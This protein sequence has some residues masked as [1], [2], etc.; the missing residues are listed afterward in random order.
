MRSTTGTALDGGDFHVIAEAMPQLVWTAD[1]SGQ[2]D[3]FNKRWIDYTG[4]GLDQYRERGTEV[5]V[6][7]PDDVKETWDRWNRA[8]ADG[9]PYELEFRLRANDGSYRWFLSRAAPIRNGDGRVARWIGTATDVNDQKRARESLRFMVEAGNVMFAA[10]EVDAICKEL[11]RLAVDHFADWCFVTLAMDGTYETVAMQHRNADMVHFV[12]QYRHRYP[13]RPGDA[14]MRAVE[15]NEKQLYERILPEQLQAA[16]RDE[17]HMRLLEF[18]QMHSVMLLPLTSNGE[19]YGA[20]TMV[21]SESGRL[22]TASDLDVAGAI[23]DRAAAAIRNA[24]MLA[25]ERRTAEQLRFTARVNEGLFGT[26]DPWPTMN[27]VAQAIASEIADACAILRLQEEGI[28]AEI[29]VHRDANTNALVS[30]LRGQRI[31]RPQAERDIAERLKKHETVVY[32]SQDPGALAERVWP[33][34]SSAAH[35][36]APR[37][38]VILPLHAGGETYGAMVGVLCATAVRRCRRAAPR[39]GCSAGF[40]RHGT[41]ENARAG[42]AN[43]DDA[44]T[45]VAPLA[46]SAPRRHPF[47]YG[48]CARRRRRPSR[49]RLV[50][51]N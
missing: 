17:E 4:I 38:S 48:I 39:G 37:T 7:H 47:R 41:L 19:T 24:R 11:A 22:F 35:A 6:V 2:V 9:T 25:A 27:G 32:T 21:S 36:L 46:H 26:S 13:P 50:R 10:T 43:R 12:E 40:G 16:A 29:V 15:Q 28:R 42:T 3:Y 31:Y 23:A 8:V 18:L 20:V 49:R 5:G 1:G 33:Y 34:L 44:P 45:G 14:F 30:P 51:R